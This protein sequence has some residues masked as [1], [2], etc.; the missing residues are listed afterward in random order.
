[1]KSTTLNPSTATSTAGTG[2]R[3]QCYND[4]SSANY[5]LAAPFTG[6]PVGTSTDATL[7]FDWGIVHRAGR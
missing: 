2:L 1:M 6:S 7:D 5:P 3:G 4:S